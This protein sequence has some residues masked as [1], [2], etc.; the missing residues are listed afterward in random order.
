[1]IINCKVHLEK[2]WNSKRMITEGD[3]AI[4]L[5]TTRCAFR[6][7]EK[8]KQRSAIVVIVYMVIVKAMAQVI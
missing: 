6:N 7:Q 5:E 2:G 8:S 4:S 1:M 3:A